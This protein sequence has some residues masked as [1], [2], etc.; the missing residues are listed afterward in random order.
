MDERAYLH[1]DD[2]DQPSRDGSLRSE[3]TRI[4]YAE[5]D[6]HQ[7]AFNWAFGP[8][9]HPGSLRIHLNLFEE[10]GWTPLLQVLGPDVQPKDRQRYYGPIPSTRYLKHLLIWG[11]QLQEAFGTDSFWH[12]CRDGCHGTLP[13][14][15]E[16]PPYQRCPGCSAVSQHAEEAVQAWLIDHPF[17]QP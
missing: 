13:T 12:R 14:T 8:Q 11:H 7:L 4:W 6:N 10:E 3:F 2:D 17:P 16:G 5:V 1:H 9:G 15:P